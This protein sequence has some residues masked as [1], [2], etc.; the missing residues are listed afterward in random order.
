MNQIE[1]NL[2]PESID[3]LK[4]HRIIRLS[5]LNKC[6]MFILNN[7]LQLC[8]TKHKLNRLYSQGKDKIEK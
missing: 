8:I 4:T 7:F 3:E 1:Q 5:C 2:S 6:K